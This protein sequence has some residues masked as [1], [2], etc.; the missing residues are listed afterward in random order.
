M[1]DLL[2]A[3]TSDLAHLMALAGAPDLGGLA[4]VTRAP[5]AHNL[6]E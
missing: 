4:G 6:E 3:M 5:A 2:T 1:R